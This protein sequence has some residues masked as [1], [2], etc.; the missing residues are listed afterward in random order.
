MSVMLVVASLV[1]VGI[2]S[3]REAEAGMGEFVNET[4]LF[5]VG[6]T[7]ALNIGVATVALVVGIRHFRR[8][9]W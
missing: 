6:A 3:Y 1:G 5:W 8:L 9:E 2:M 7:L 4:L